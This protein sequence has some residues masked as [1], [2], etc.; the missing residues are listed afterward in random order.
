[1]LEKWAGSCREKKKK[2]DGD[3]VVHWARIELE[4]TTIFT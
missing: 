1:M 4:L 2:R 3:G